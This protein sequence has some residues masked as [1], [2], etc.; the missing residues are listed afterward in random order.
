MDILLSTDNNYVMPTGVLMTSVSMNNEDIQYHV[1]VGSE[2]SNENKGLLTKIAQKYNDAICFYSVPSSW[3]SSLPVGKTGQRT[4]VSLA[5][6][7][8]LFISEILPKK[9][10]KVLYLDGD[11]IVRHPLDELWNTDLSGLALGVVHDMDETIHLERRNLP[12]PKEDGYFNAGMLLINLDYWREHDC[13]Q[14][15]ISFISK[16]ADLLSCHDQDVLNCVLHN[17][18]KWVP[19]TYNFQHGFLYDIPCI[20]E[21]DHALSEEI[22]SVERNPIVIHFCEDYKPWHY[23]CQHPQRFVWDY[24]KNKSLWK[25]FKP[26]IDLTLRERIS[27]FLKKNNYWFFE[28]KANSL[29]RNI[30]RNVMLWK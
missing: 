22:R 24:Y 3:T 7:N 20:Q 9:I 30:Y 16:N 29:H 14:R 5:T 23:L 8:R 18:K 2:F 6:Y 10:H 25:S 28:H 26:T 19:L 4:Y 1:L 13:L 17:E 12:Y 21:Y 15:F 27:I 11:M